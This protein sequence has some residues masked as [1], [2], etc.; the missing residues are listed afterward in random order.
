MR[1]LTPTVASSVAS[2]VLASICHGAQWTFENTMARLTISDDAIVRAV[3]DAD[4]RDWTAP[5]PSRLGYIKASG[6]THTASAIAREGDDLVVTYGQSGLKTRLRLTARPAYFIIELLETPQE[7]VEE[8]CFFEVGVKIAEHIGWWLDVR[9]NDQFAVC[10]MGCSPRVHTAGLR[11]RVYPEFGMRGEKVVLAATPTPRFLDIVQLVEKELAMPSPTIGGQ[12]A[13][14]SDD[15]RRGYLFSDLTEANAEETIR[16]AKL[17]EFAYIMTYSD[18]WSTSLGSY[19]INTRNFP[20][21]EASLKATV[22]RLHAAGLKAGLHMLTSFVG[23]NDPLVRPVPDKRLLKDAETSLSADIDDSAALLP[24]AGPLDGFPREKAFYGESSQG[25]SLLVDDEIIRYGG[26]GDD[27]RSFVQCRRGANGTKPAAHKAGAKVYHLVERYGCYMADLRTT[28]KD[29]IAERVAGVVN[30]C[31]FDMIYFD[32]GECNAANG[33]YWYWVTP[34]QLA[35]WQRFTRDVLV[36]GSG[37]TAWTWHIFARGCCDDFAAVAPKEYLDHHKI[38]DSWRYYTDSFMPAELGWWGFLDDA[39]AH[40]PTMPD[41]VEYY[42]VRMLALDTPVSLETRLSSLKKNGRTEEMLAL[43]GR[44]E[45]LR[46]GGKV[47]PAVRA[48][49]R[50][51]EW[52]MTG[53]ESRPAFAP[54]RYDVYRVKPGQA[55]KVD[56]RF[57]SQSLKF[58]LQAVPSLAEPG[59]ARNIVLLSATRPVP[60]SPPGDK[61]PMP[62]ALA[63]AVDFTAPAGHQVRGMPADLVAAAS[64]QRPSPDWPGRP[65]DL[66][67]HRALAVT[68]RVESPPA[69]GAPCPVLNIQLQTTSQMYRDHYIDLDFQGERTVVIPEPNTHRLLPEFRPPHAAYPFKQAM[70]SFDYRQIEALNLR[71]MRV[72]GGGRVNCAIV[73]VEALA[74]SDS[75]LENAALTVENN[76]PVVAGTLKTGDYAESWGTGPVRV[77]DRNGMLLRTMGA[78]DAPQLPQ[79][80]TMA[81]V[82]AA[83]AGAA[84][85]TVITLGESFSW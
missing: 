8:I 1:P 9:W 73:R 69:A 30:R 3:V 31:G 52:H 16:Y 62:G 74:E 49:L 43:L 42:A 80:T 56:N 59:D 75:V 24:V 26:I 79:G 78:G 76:P 15:V 53:D 38:R 10:L 2:I 83:G 28:L 61:A 34:Q 60:V 14:R 33:P 72:P 6:R 54:V 58:R 55:V 44:Y 48:R 77:F 63:G 57:A 70:Y 4:G 85:L 23:W 39:P 71:W 65:L 27:G 40:G 67:R 21:G 64:G 68:L 41:E 46:L 66:T 5:K 82:K 11:A 51:G 17:G 18:T 36:Q 81:A 84:R 29:E 13:K 35:V 50:E 37:G 19:P 7:Q 32:G 20:Q 47:P 22:D 45:R 12:W 25:F